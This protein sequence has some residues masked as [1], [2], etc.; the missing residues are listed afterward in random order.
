MIDVYAS[1]H[2]LLQGKT[3]GRSGGWSKPSSAQAGRPARLHQSRPKLGGG[4]E[5]WYE[6]DRLAVGLGARQHP[7]ADREAALMQLGNH[8]RGSARSQQWSYS[9][10]TS[11]SRLYLSMHWRSWMLRFYTACSCFSRIPTSHLLPPKRR[12]GDP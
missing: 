9:M 7:P 6:Y 11:R 5:R 3:A 12:L 2:L 8:S 1:L 4:D 10:G